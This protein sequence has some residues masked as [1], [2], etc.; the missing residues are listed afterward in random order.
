MG[1]GTGVHTFPFAVQGHLVRALSAQDTGQHRERRPTRRAP[2][3][4]VL[5]ARSLAANAGSCSGILTFATLELVS[6]AVPGLLPCTSG[7]PCV[8][9]VAPDGAGTPRQDQRPS[10]ILG[11]AWNNWSALDPKRTSR[12]TSNAA[13]D[14]PSADYGGRRDVRNC[15]RLFT[16]KTRPK[17]RKND[18]VE[19]DLP[20]VW[21][22]V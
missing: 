21:S 22:D 8:C 17:L 16:E 12:L 14:A 11:V 4:G 10:F 6:S 9:P 20:M 19:R 18:R 2:L 15:L 7:V 13:S 3:P 1:G 5:L